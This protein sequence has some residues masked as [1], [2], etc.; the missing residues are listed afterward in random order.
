MK[1][2]IA[3]GTVSVVLLVGLLALVGFSEQSRM[4]SFTRAYESRQIEAGAALYENNCRSCHGPQGKGIEG[5][6]PAVNAADLY[7]GQRLIELGFSGT[8]EDYVAGV[9]AAG[10]PVP[11]A[12]ANY[13]QRMPTWGQEYG[14]PLRTDEIESL[15]GFIMNWEDRS[16][17]EGEPTPLAAGEMVGTDIDVT[18]PPGDAQSGQS[19]AAGGLGCAGC[20]ELAP[21]GPAWGAEGD[22]P[23]LAIR[24]DTRIAQDDYTGAA[25]TAAEYLIESVVQT[26]TFLVAGYDANIMPGNYGER[27]SAQE[28]ADL[29]AYMLSFE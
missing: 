21:V 28:L 10:R 19:L 22:D 12:G 26:N 13:P 1:W 11:S 7:S 20:H 14:G 5:V 6:A 24:A 23:G 25:S 17:A 3:L 2:H 15:V 4:A 16:L 9:I 29:L 8:V 27:L 18:L